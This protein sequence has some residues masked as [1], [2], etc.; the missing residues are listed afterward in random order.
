MS[1]K[2]YILDT[3]V[4]IHDPESIFHF[5][6]NEV[7]IPFEALEEL[8]KLKKRYDQTGQNARQ[9]IR[10]LGGLV[11]SGCLSEGLQ[12]TE[13]GVLKVP[14][15]FLQNGKSR[16]SIVALTKELSQNADN[17]IIAL[18]LFYKQQHNGNTI[19]VSKDINA[20]VKAQA[21]GIR[22]EDYKTDKID[23]ATIYTGQTSLI[24]GRE[25]IHALHEHGELNVDALKDQE[26]VFIENQC[27]LLTSPNGPSALAIHK[28]GMLHKVDHSH[29]FL[30]GVR[31]K[32]KDQQ[33]SIEL[34]T[35]NT[36]QAVSLI[37]KA[38]TGKTILALAVG[39]HKTLEEGVFQRI[40]VT[41]PVVPV[42]RQD[43]GFL[44][45]DKEDKMLPWVQSIFDNLVPLSSNNQKMTLDYLMAAHLL[46]IE[47]IAHIRG[48]SIAKSWIIIDEAQNLTPHEVKTILSRVGEGSKIVLTGDIYQIDS[49]YLD[50]GSNGLSYLVSK[51]KGQ[52]LYGHIMLNKTIRSA[53]ASLAAE[54]L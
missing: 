26:Q 28:N 51:F 54:L 48:R 31:P 8:D 40:F 10:Y 45:G 43:I 13:G 6:E 42:G 1:K 11:E 5:Q 39:L 32:N 49:P 20:R 24:V 19:F 21:L 52:L 17:R 41:K 14:P 2:T 16:K 44:P 23:I 25:T 53:L 27:F 18:A 38:G 12:L 37:G 9:T 35:D 47:S 50:A 33:F 36:I 3:N 15:T 7:I 46:E 4:L 34:L 22:A 30:W 29:T